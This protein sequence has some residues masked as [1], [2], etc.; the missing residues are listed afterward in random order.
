MKQLQDYG[1]IV[2]IDDFGSGYSSLNSLK[3]IP[4]DVLKLDMKFFERT[5][6]AERAQ[7]VVES[8]V[9]L[10]YNLK[11]LVIAEGVED[12]E[13]LELLKA[14]GCRIV[15]GFYYS[16]PLPV[17]EFEKYAKSHTFEDIDVIIDELHS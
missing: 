2:E 7:K 8:I 5:D 13:K 4:A 15:Q 9:N 10:A 6:D 14:I 1:F 17:K 16:R 12:D 3:D 11:M